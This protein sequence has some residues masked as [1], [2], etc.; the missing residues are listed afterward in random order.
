MNVFDF[1]NTI[2]R[3]ESTIDFF[4]FCLRKKP[5]M[6]RYLPAIFWQLLRY[7]CGIIPAESIIAR[8]ERVLRCFLQEIRDIDA[9]VSEFW[10]RN[11]HKIKAQFREML[12]EDDLILSGSCEILLAEICRRL[13]VQNFLGTRV[14]LDACRVEFL[15]YHENKVKAFQEHYP[16]ETIHLFYSDSIHDLPIAQLADRAFRVR[17]DRVTPWI[18]PA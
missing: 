16:T 5:S 15:C 6:I 11:E 18:E 12:R 3:G 8:G 13:G 7:K 4:R 1:D 17:G 9:L 14:D 2:Y 10:D